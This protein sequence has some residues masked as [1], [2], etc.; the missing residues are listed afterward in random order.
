MGTKTVM[1]CIETHIG[2]IPLPRYKQYTTISHVEHSYFCCLL[3]V[4]FLL[5]PLTKRLE[6]T[7][8]DFNIY[9]VSMYEVRVPGS[10]ALA[11]VII[12]VT[13]YYASDATGVS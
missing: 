3:Y 6:V 10:P 8:S 5:H 1:F 13:R 11:A 9:T 12:R 2:N 7:T 4:V